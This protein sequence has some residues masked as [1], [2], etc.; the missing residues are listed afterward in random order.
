MSKGKLDKLNAINELKQ[1]QLKLMKKI[2]KIA[3]LRPGKRPSTA[4]NRGFQM[5]SIMIKCKMIQTQ[6]RMIAAH[7]IET[8]KKETIIYI[9]K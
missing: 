6:I 4:I 7:P 5:M 2:F 8:C 9:S 1:Q 3:M